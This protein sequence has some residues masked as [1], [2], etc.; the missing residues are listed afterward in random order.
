MLNYVRSEI[1]TSAP[2]DALSDA[3]LIVR[4]PACTT[5]REQASCMLAWTLMLRI[6]GANASCNQIRGTHL[7]LAKQW[8]VSVGYRN[9]ERV[10]GFRTKRQ[11]VQPNS[12]RRRVALKPLGCRSHSPCISSCQ[13]R[14]PSQMSPIKQPFAAH[15]DQ[16]A[17][18]CW[19]VRKGL[20]RQLARVLSPA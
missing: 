1:P 18:V 17:E 13:Q 4:M 16:C 3:P 12:K 20:A 11:R 6:V 7:R 9:E 15:D 2:C 14:P 8:A 10:R 5:E 19:S